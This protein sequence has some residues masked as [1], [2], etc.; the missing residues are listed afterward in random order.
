MKRLL[1]VSGAL[2]SFAVGNCALAQVTNGG[3]T[4]GDQSLLVKVNPIAYPQM[5][6][7]ARVTGDVRI[8]VKLLPDGR[9][10]SVDVLSGSP[11]LKSAAFESAKRSIYECRN[12]SKEGATISLTYTFALRE[13]I[14]CSVTKLR[15]AKCLYM[16]KCGGYRENYVHRPISVTQSGNHVTVQADALCVQTLSAQP[17]RAI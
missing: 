7:I 12:C 5:A 2:L 8:R 14:D 10:Y 3:D 9:V 16:W 6:K 4:G 13:D 17:K 11:L 1:W 15:S